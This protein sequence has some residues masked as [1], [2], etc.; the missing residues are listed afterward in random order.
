MYECVYVCT[1]V[2]VYAYMLSCEVIVLNLKEGHSRAYPVSP[3]NSRHA[4]REDETE[5][6]T[7]LL[8]ET[9]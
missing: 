2:C 4:G 3:V 1:Y 7:V 9:L 6:N 5:H 8:H